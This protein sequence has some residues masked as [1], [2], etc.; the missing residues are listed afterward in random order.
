MTE[1]DRASAQK[2]KLAMQF[3]E[4]ALA[5]GG[6]SS[7]SVRRLTFPKSPYERPPIK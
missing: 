5:L 6:L 3:D 7:T 4:R 2:P 1:E